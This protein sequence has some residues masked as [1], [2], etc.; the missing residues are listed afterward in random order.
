MVLHSQ[1]KKK[2]KQNADDDD[3]INLEPPKTK[4]NST[5][6]HVTYLVC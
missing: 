1:K 6:C 2:T 5:V 4:P 3:K